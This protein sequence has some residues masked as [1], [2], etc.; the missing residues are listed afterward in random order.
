[1]TQ[2]VIGAMSGTQ[3]QLTLRMKANRAMTRLL[4][5]T[6]PTFR[7]KVRNQIIDCRSQ[8]I[9]NLAPLFDDTLR[10]EQI[11]VMGGESKIREYESLFR[12]IHSYGK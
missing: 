3:T 6:P 9:R 5:K 1:M 10:T 7:Q 11:A 4:S 2:Y 8:D 12:E